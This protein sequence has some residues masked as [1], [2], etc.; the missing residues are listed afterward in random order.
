[1]SVGAQVNELVPK[2]ERALEAYK[3]CKE[4]IEAVRS[5]LEETLGEQKKSKDQSS[6]Y[7]LSDAKP[8]GAQTTNPISRVSREPINPKELDDEV[9]F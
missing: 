8:R 7:G 6:D 1:M 4:R 5:R 2:V 3:V 9:P